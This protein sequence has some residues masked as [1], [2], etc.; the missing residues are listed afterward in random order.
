LIKEKSIFDRYLPSTGSA[1]SD[2][3]SIAD[4]TESPTTNAASTQYSGGDLDCDDFATH[5]EAQQLF[6]QDPSDPHD[7]DGDGDGVACE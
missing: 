4:V 1:S 7:L 3:V 5:E 6:N 2:N